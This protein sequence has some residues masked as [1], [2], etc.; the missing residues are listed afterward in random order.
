MAIR[1]ITDTA[2]DFTVEEAS[3]LGLGLVPMTITHQGKTYRCEYELSRSEFYR[4]LTETNELP[5]TSQPAPADY[6]KL[7]RDAKE[8]GDDAICICISAALSGTCQSAQIAKMDV[9][10]DRIHIF[11]SRTGAAAEKM[12]VTEALRLAKE[13]ISAEEII[14]KLSSLR[15][16]MGLHAALDTLEYLY[17]G[18]RLTAVEAGAG[19]I[20]RI[21]PVVTI[22]NE[23]TVAVAGKSIGA[24]KAFDHLVQILK[25]QDLDP[26]Y[27]PVFLYSKDPTA[28]HKLM[29][30][31][32]IPETER[33]SRMVELGGTIGTHVGP[34][35]YGM[36]YVRRA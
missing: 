29:D 34:G 11:D 10:Y 23:G 24:K 3:A 27:P 2:S 7:F 22:S 31:F 30:A 5:K 26:D 6:A 32:N 14:E 17:K 1:I 35:V 13:N 9:D 15:D 19:I 18:G 25:S 20:M 21:K 16:R 4:L 12:L 36:A 8:A 33:E 28:C